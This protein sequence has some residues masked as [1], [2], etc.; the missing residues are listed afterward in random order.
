M[1]RQELL[2]NLKSISSGTVAHAIGN[3]KYSAIDKAIQNSILY[4]YEIATD[5]EI[6]TIDCNLASILDFIVSHK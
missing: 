2:I 6:A 5:A 4:A 3:C 1:T